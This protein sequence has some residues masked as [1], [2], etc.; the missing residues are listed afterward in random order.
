MQQSAAGSSP[1]AL[2]AV[3]QG[4]Q[5]QRTTVATAPMLKIHTNAA[6]SSLLLRGVMLLLLLLMVDNSGLAGLQH[7]A[8][9]KGKFF[10]QKQQNITENFEK[11][12][13]KN[14][15][16]WEQAIKIER[17]QKPKINWSLSVATCNIRL[18]CG[19]HFACYNAFS[20]QLKRQI[21]QAYCVCVCVPINLL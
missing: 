18:C 16:T 21:Q 9:L 7:V 13:K 10:P 19:T 17:K 2:D 8:A 14:R 5:R 15:R 3:W 11:R 1:H 12:E 4:Q 6:A 20:G